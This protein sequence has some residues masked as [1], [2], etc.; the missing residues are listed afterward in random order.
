MKR[1]NVAAAAAVLA[2][3]LA[4]LSGCVQYPTERQGVSDM[5][6]QMS[7]RF[8]PA[9]PRMNDARVIVNGLDTGRMADY[10]DGKGALRVLP[11]THTVR[12]VSGNDVLLDERAYLGDGVARPF[13]VK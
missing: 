4:G 5:R 6:P 10:A 2:L 1:A 9:D 12:V 8:N 11:G 7:F 3:A 13:I